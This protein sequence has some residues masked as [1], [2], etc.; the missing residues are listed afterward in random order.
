MYNSSSFVTSTITILSDVL[1]EAFSTST[2]G[3]KPFHSIMYLT[4]KCLVVWSDMYVYVPLSS[5]VNTWVI[6]PQ[7]ISVSIIA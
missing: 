1:M 3:L 6:N 7:N 4:Y 5:T 2:L